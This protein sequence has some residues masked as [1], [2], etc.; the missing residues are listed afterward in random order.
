M[1]QAK[2]LACPAMF[3]DFDW[4]SPYGPDMSRSRREAFVYGMI[5]GALVVLTGS[6]LSWSSRLSLVTDLVW[7]G[8]SILVA[9]AAAASSARASGAALPRVLAAAGLAFLL[10]FFVVNV[11]DY[12]LTVLLLMPDAPGPFQGQP[13]LSET[14]VATI[15]DAW[16]LRRHVAL[17]ALGIIGGSGLGVWRGRAAA[18]ESDAR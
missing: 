9:P 11:V 4:G 12:G 7:F 18:K 5:G 13:E 16:L 1:R 17:C 14:D 10:A 3:V 15:A 2:Q 6:L 8:L